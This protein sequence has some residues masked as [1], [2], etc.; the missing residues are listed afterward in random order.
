[1]Q[2]VIIAAP[3]QLRIGRRDQS[4]ELVGVETI[5]VAKAK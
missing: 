5:C 4:N 3:L 1:M 2:I